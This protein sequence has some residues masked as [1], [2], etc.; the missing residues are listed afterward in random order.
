MNTHTP[1]SRPSRESRI[2]C[3]NFNQDQGCFAIG[4]ENGFLVYNT[5]PIDLR[6]KRTFNA[7]PQAPQAP[8][9]GSGIGHITMLHRTN[10]L[11]LVGGGKTPKFANNKLIIWD[12]LKRK[13]SLSLEFTSPVLNVLLSRIRII[14]VLKN[15]VL[16]YGFSAPPKKFATYE[17]I[18]NDLGLA[19]L[20]VNS[21][22]PSSLN[23][24]GSSSPSLLSVT[25]ASSKDT[26]KY[27]TLAFPGRQVGQIQL[28]DV[29]P[30]GQEKNLVSIIKAHKSKIRCL[31]LNRSGT[32]IASASETGTIIRVH[33]THNTGLLYEFRRGLDRAIITSMKFSHNDSKLAVLSDK[34]TLHIFNLSD[35][36]YVSSSSSSPASSISGLG[37][38]NTYPMNRRHL[39]K[40][41]P[42]P[43][44]VP[45]YFNSTWS[46]CSINTN[47]YHTDFNTSGS[48]L[49]TPTGGTDVGVL[50]W[51]GNDS[52]IIIWKNK[53][54]WERYVLVENKTSEEK[55]EWELVRY[56]WKTLDSLSE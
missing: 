29:S 18:D 43:I 39:L 24:S 28:V 51:S 36:T 14:V 16:V 31:A 9:Y 46:F 12:D 49:H 45:N 22:S 52:I 26:N 8:S 4:H 21:T 47:Q 40:S 7:P 55:S 17:T 53:R 2:L 15:Q 54:I 20:S 1:L 25:S 34:N 50:G 6:V 33:S 38:S 41:M 35:P 32:L 42:I 48:L 23:L 5:N 3:I 27:Q 30:Q 13:N 37:R 56:S 19:D 10:Y 44:P 11:A